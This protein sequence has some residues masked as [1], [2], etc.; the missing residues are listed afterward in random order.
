MQK[1]LP[2]YFFLLLASFS[3][4]SAAVPSKKEYRYYLSAVAIFRDEANYLREWIEYHKLL[5]V[6]HFYL[7]NNLSEDDYR[8]VLQPYIE[9]GVVDLT[10]WS[11][12]ND[13]MHSWTYIQRAAYRDAID[14]SHDKTKWL[15]ICDTDEFFVPIQHNSLAS[16]IASEEGK[17][18]NRKVARYE[19][20]WVLF[21][22][23]GIEK[24]PQNKLMIEL[25]TMNE[26]KKS[27]LVKSIVRP[28]FVGSYIN[29]HITNLTDGMKSRNLSLAV[30][31]INHYMLRD[32]HF[33]YEVKIPRVAR[34]YK[35]TDHLFQ[36][37]RLCCH[38]NPYSQKILRFIPELKKRLGLH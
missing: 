18:N 9:S 11:Y 2:L 19:I 28:Q 3:F 20:N 30:A 33:L 1:K 5:G 8:S 38:I 35:H 31:Q 6:E 7:Y 16:L 15:A 23:S 24:I 13:S 17:K 36:V 14:R 32:R 12:E 34:Y 4:L 29:P 10:D 21:G 26:G 37:D 25:L 27:E 22:T